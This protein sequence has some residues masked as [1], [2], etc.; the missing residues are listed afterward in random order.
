MRKGWS[1]MKPVPYIKTFE[2]DLPLQIKLAR[3][4]FDS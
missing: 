4:L 3:T 2:H 1:I